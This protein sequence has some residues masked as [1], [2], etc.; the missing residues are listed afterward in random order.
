[1]KTIHRV[2]YAND[3]NGWVKCFESTNKSEA[4]KLLKN[5]MAK[6]TNDE[7]NYLLSHRYVEISHRD[8]K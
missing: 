1:M 6:L 4:I 7:K 5:Y 8:N 2:G 3:R